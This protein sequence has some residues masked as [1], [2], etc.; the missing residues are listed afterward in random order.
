[1]PRDDSV[2]Q[3]LHSSQQ[4]ERLSSSCEDG[5]E[6]FRMSIN[7][8]RLCLLCQN[9]ERELQNTAPT[10]VMPFLFHY[11]WEGGS[12]SLHLKAHSGTAFCPELL[13][14]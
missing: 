6:D 5:T 12:G 1:M 13:W 14:Q 11:P 10:Q 7:G 8:S 4:Q 3:K 2:V 9:T